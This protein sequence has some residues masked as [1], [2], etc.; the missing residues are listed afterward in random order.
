MQPIEIRIKEQVNH[1]PLST[2]FQL[3]AA[4]GQSKEGHE[5]LNIY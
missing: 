2:D 1:R 3:S 4:G 5:L